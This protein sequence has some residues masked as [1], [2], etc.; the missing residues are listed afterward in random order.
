LKS[1]SK[2]SFNDCLIVAAELGA[3]AGVIGAA[4]LAF[5]VSKSQGV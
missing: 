2:E 3:E 1:A 4:L 5:E